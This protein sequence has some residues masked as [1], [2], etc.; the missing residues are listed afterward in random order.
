MNTNQF[1]DI[2]LS[3]LEHR[4]VVHFYGIY[5]QT[6]SEKYLVMEFMNEGSLLVLLQLNEGSFSTNLLLNM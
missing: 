3:K 6:P 4:N 2:L 1:G 5:Y